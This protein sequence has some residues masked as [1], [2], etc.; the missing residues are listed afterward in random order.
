MPEPII[1]TDPLYQMLRNENV[2]GF[3]AARKLGKTCDLRHCHLRGLDLR[4]TDF[5]NLDLSGAYFRGA[6][7]RGIDFSTCI[8]E[9]VSLGDA[10][11]SGCYFPRSIPANELI[12]SVSYGTRIRQGQFTSL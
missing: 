8:M 10:Q 11:I 9:G 2:K 3:N 1:S 4:G 7:L 6:D 5:S 12:M